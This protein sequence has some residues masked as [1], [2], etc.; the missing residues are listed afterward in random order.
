MRI[1]VTFLLLIFITHG[2]IAQRILVDTTELKVKPQV[3]FDQSGKT[4]HMPGNFSEVY[5]FELKAY[6]DAQFVF[7]SWMPVNRAKGYHIYRREGN[8]L[9]KKINKK[10]ISWPTDSAQTIAQYQKLLPSPKFNLERVHIQRATIPNKPKNEIWNPPFTNPYLEPTFRYLGKIY[11]QVALIIGQGFADSTVTSGTTYTYKIAWVDQADKETDFG[12]EVTVTAGKLGILSKTTGVKAEAGDSEILLRWKDPPDPDA[13]AGF[14]VYKST[15]TSGP[16]VRCDSVPVLT[17]VPVDLQGD[18]LKPAPFGFLDSDAKNYTTYYYRISSRNPLG[19]VGP[20]SDIV[21]AMPRDLTPPELIKNMDVTPLKTNQLLLTWNWVSKDVKKRDDVVKQYRIFKYNDFET[22]M[23]DTAATSQAEIGVVTE[24]SI[25]LISDTVRSY[26]DNKVIPEK[27]YWYRISCED[28]AGNIGHKSAALSGILPDYEPPDSATMSS[29]EGFD[30]YIR[31]SWNP[32]D[33]TAKKNQDL[34]GYLLYRGICGGYNEIIK[35]DEGDL[36]VFHAYPLHLLADIT[37][38]DTTVYKDYSLPKGSP[39]CYRY[40]LKCYDKAQNLSVMSDSLCERLRDKTPPDPPVITALQAR[41][42]SLKIECIAPPVQ[43]MKGFVIERSDNKT[44][45]Y[46]EV[47]S[48]AV[49][50][51]AKCGDFP[52]SVDS[53]LEMK[54]NQLIYTDQ[55]LIPA[56]VY[57]YRVRAFDYDGNKSAP[58]PPVSSYTYEIKKLL[59]PGPPKADLVKQRDGSCI[60]RL[61]W[62]KLDNIDEKFMGYVVYR[63][64]DKQKGYRQLNQ[65]STIPEYEDVS[66]VSNMTYWYKIQAFDK[67]GDRSPASDAVSITILK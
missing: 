58:S 39:I 12:G 23:A 33:L 54:V 19:R 36:Y 64:I 5:K 32:P 59:K 8:Q 57:W 61:S 41:S 26:T 42:T 11:Y 44:G 55:N 1:I 45:P 52:A 38:K 17:R 21:S 13:L 27:V 18:S 46:Q 63:S 24:P 53:V 40:A 16:F 29:A 47:Y 56:K 25:R 20:L 60:V 4:D 3:Q 14:H 10:R 35:R 31:V 49:P 43:D 50:P 15:S 51:R 62:K 37:D 30:D 9:Y 48:D 2:S 66:V 67:N 6:V 65:L 34:T 28:T 7:L 22:A